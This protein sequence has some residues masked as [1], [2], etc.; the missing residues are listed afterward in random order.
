MKNKYFHIN[1]IF[2]LFFLINITSFSQ[3]NVGIGTDKPNPKAVLELS[4]ENPTTSPQ[5]FLLPRLTTTQRIAFGTTLGTVVGMAV[6]DTDD[7]TF[8]TWDG[9]QWKSTGSI[10]SNIIGKDGIVVT[11]I[12]GNFT[13]SGGNSQWISNGNDK[14]YTMS[15]VG[16]GI[17]N[18]LTKLHIA[19]NNQLDL[20]LQST[21]R[22]VFNVLKTR[23]TIISP[24][25]VLVGDELGALMFSG[26]GSTTPQAGAE[27]VGV[28]QETFTDAAAGTSLQFRTSDIGTS[29]ITTKMT[30]S[31]SGNIGI[32]TISPNEK[33]T[34]NGNSSVSGIGYFS[35]ISG[36][37]L[38]GA[39][40]GSI[41]TVDGLGTLGFGT[42]PTGTPSQWTTS[43]SNI[44]YRGTTANNG[45][46][47]IGTNAPADPLDL[48]YTPTTGSALVGS[49]FN[50]DYSFGITGA[51]SNSGMQ[52]NNT[53][54]PGANSTLSKS[55]EVISTFNNEVSTANH[56]SVGVLTQLSGTGSGV[57]AGVK[58]DITGNLPNSIKI[59]YYTS[60]FGQGAKNIGIQ[61]YAVG[62]TLNYAAIFDRG[63]VGIGLQTP[64]A[65]LH[66][67]G[68]IRFE[69]YSVAGSVL[70]V[71][72]A[73]NLGVGTL[74]FST[75]QTTLTGA[76][77]I[78]ISGSGF[79][80]TISGPNIVS[81]QWISASANQIYTNSFVGIGTSTPLNLLHVASS[82]NN[83]AGFITSS[84]AD[85]SN[86]INLYSGRVGAN[87]ASIGFRNT[88]DLA[89]GT[90]AAPNNEVSYIERMRLTNNG[91]LGI[92]TTA[93]P[94]ERLVV[95]GNQ[96]VTG[97]SYLNT[98]I[99]LNLF[100]APGSVVT[101]DGAG[102]LGL[103]AALTSSQ[104]TT[105]TN[106][107]FYHSAGNVAIGTATNLTL[108]KLVVVEDASNNPSIF[109]SG[110]GPGRSV[111]IQMGR[112][113]AADGGIGIA[114]VAGTFS[115]ISNL[116]DMVVRA[117]NNLILSAKGAGKDIMFSTGL[118]ESEKMRITNTGNL[119]IGTTNPNEKLTV[120]G[121]SSVSG[122][123]YFGTLIGNNLSGAP[124]SVITVD[125]IG[126]LGF[127]SLPSAI[128]S[129]QLGGNSV[130]GLTNFGTLTNFDL[131]FF[132]NGSEKMRIS[133]AGN[134]GIGLTTP[135][136]YKLTIVPSFNN[137]GILIDNQNTGFDAVINLKTASAV[138]NDAAL[139]L[140]DSDGQ[141]LKIA[142]GN[143]NTDANR[144]ASTRLV[145]D[146]N[147]NIGIGT[148][149][150]NEK[151]TVQGN[152]SVSGIG[153]FGTL[154]G[155]NLSG[156]PGSVITVDGTGRLGIGTLLQ[157]NNYWQPNGANKIYSTSFVGI[158]ET[159]P[160]VPLSIKSTDNTLPAVLKIVRDVTGGTDPQIGIDVAFSG[161][162]TSNSKI[163]Y[164]VQVN[165]PGSENVRGMSS[166]ITQNNTTATG[167]LIATYSY[168]NNNGP[169]QSF[170]VNAISDG[171]GTG[172][173]YG[174]GVTD[175]S[176]GVSER[177]GVAA[178]MSGAGSGTNYAIYG[179][180]I[181]SSANNYSGYFD[182]GK[183][184]IKDNL[185]I[186]TLNPTAKL[187]IIGTLRFRNLLNG[188]LTVDGTGNV[189]VGTMPNA[190]Q[191]TTTTNGI[192]YNSP[193]V[194]IG[195]NQP[196]ATTGLEIDMK[197]T[198]N[199]ALQLSSSGAGWGSGIRFGN[200]GG[201]GKT[202]GIYSSNVG[203]FH[204]ADATL[205]LDRLIIDGN[206]NIGIG[207]LLSPLA[208]LDVQGDVR[209]SSTLTLSGMAG[210]NFSLG[211]NANGQV[212]TLTSPLASWKST[213][214][215]VTFTDDKIAI[216]TNTVAGAARLKVAGDGSMGGMVITSQ[217]L[218]NP[219]STS[220]TT[221]TTL[222]TVPVYIPQGTNTIE[223]NVIG[224]SQGGGNVNFQLDIN[225][226]TSADITLN[227]PTPT[228][229]TTP[230]SLNVAALNGWQTLKI[231]VANTA[232]NANA[233]LHGYTV[234]VKN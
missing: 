87:F 152:S 51:L 150:P 80:Q 172:T 81:S 131:P 130:A 101:V 157:G 53:V 181:N 160:T 47:G 48:F 223:F 204:F 176:T 15:T 203:R 175:L 166:Q 2:I 214:A 60:V 113:L 71:D 64:T 143:T 121:N 16:I 199:T 189:G 42:M 26:Q 19:D 52:I 129:W 50:Y 127:G 100:G 10:V 163:G 154:I 17:A 115:G 148:T 138:D 84:N 76:N 226:N 185:G 188:I 27:I 193:G 120:Q 170:A 22:S 85:N 63:L 68:N 232:G 7:K 139:F 153:Y 125:G 134:L 118:V 103:G 39:V 195:N 28:A 128:P 198:N 211:V 112:N 213:T 4:V 79:S 123:G 219:M 30:L 184:Y 49:R 186:G 201:V 217:S 135:A 110:G 191:W 164:N 142:L 65:Q 95:V 208:K 9:T 229:G 167:Q 224:S 88:G 105:T 218:V 178:I 20:L 197:T 45:F 173:R 187:D 62:G 107:I 94:T 69:S 6:Y 8:Y 114:G 11:N 233:I 161:S 231:N 230:Q 194:V 36:L 146:Q 54:N 55:L 75:T 35:S 140:D 90:L 74:N 108:G 38:N 56:F 25:Q 21:N 192:F 225:A 220:N 205:G 61:A 33:L 13:I 136:P 222:I 92:G 168:I 171:T 183:V 77:G 102:K 98:I 212:I 207:A 126:R 14:I 24:T 215:G 122:I 155:N 200:T 133:T 111:S 132:T 46:V 31:S 124:G 162:Q 91:N 158:G 169:A 40:A 106:G 151:L 37:A 70:T 206:G 149:N 117:E 104:W 57:V 196:S 78:S 96:S 12:G 99:G 116:G 141:K 73:G 23:G 29:N 34:V 210:G 177:Y 137:D 180:A 66:V 44:Y 41:V 159:L 147:G 182:D 221:Y 190:S 209:I 227:N 145:I 97:I 3:K 165:N 5:G 86:F 234:I 58:S 156:A 174:V 59:G 179:K 144:L 93:P 67:L 18:P 72:G 43:G 32:G 119:G 228:I 109:A 89:F 82:A 83:I 202:Y 1:L 216:G